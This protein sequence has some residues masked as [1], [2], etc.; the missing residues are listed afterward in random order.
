MFRCV[1][2]ISVSDHVVEAIMPFA[3]SLAR[4][5][6]RR[7]FKNFKLLPWRPIGGHFALRKRPIRDQ[8]SAFSSRIRCRRTSKETPRNSCPKMTSGSALCRVTVRGLEIIPVH[9]KIRIQTKKIVQ[10][11]TLVRHRW[12]DTSPIWLGCR[13]EIRRKAI[14]RADKGVYRARKLIRWR[15]ILDLRCF[16]SGHSIYWQWA[17]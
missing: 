3:P 2:H 5:H 7:P 9:L 14:Q 17:T 16:A 11:C 8:W 6:S 12:Y 1:L 10:Q 15:W 13:F 4:S